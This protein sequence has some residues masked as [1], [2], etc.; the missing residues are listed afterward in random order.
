ML[1][2]TG[3]ENLAR[4]EQLLSTDR[5]FLGRLFQRLVKMLGNT[6]PNST[7]RDGTNSINSI[8][9]DLAMFF[10]GPL[11]SQLERTLKFIN[12][13]VNSFI[14][15]LD[16]PLYNWS[17]NFKEAIKSFAKSAVP[18]LF[19]SLRGQDSTREERKS[20]L[21]STVKIILTGLNLESI[22]IDSVFHLLFSNK[23]ETNAELQPILGYIFQSFST[24]LENITKHGIE[25]D[26]EGC[27]GAINEV[28]RLTF[29][30]L[31]GL[32]DSGGDGAGSLV[33]V[34]SWGTLSQK[35]KINTEQSSKFTV[36]ALVSWF[37]WDNF[38]NEE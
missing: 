33:D 23:E 7:E 37:I 18:V 5:V 31:P 35:E 3:S 27:A 21:K 36:P 22:G 30:Y 16:S 17:D 13:S 1:S 2:G 29:A 15:R 19:N 24:V 14:T 10:G 26:E 25:I 4:S 20:L 11:E 28:A 32:L 38:I 34:E 8:L 12:N 6:I 9:I